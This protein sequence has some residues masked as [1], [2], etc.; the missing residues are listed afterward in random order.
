MLHWDSS[1]QASGS[2]M[3]MVWS[4]C[5]SSFRRCEHV[6]TSTLGLVEIWRAHLTAREHIPEREACPSHG[7][8]GTEWFR[9]RSL[10]LSFERCGPPGLL[11]LRIWRERPTSLKQSLAS[12]GKQQGIPARFPLC[13]SYTHPDAHGRGPSP[14]KG[15]SKGRLLAGLLADEHV[16]Q[17]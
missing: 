6:E 14:C 10:S 11:W 7:W 15:P 13:V 8:Q 3:A 2:S 5:R 17:S 16:R 9:S 1:E 12:S 4:V